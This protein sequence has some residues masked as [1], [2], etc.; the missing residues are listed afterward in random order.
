MIQA[1][2]VQQLNGHPEGA[3]D[4][5]LYWMTHSRRVLDN[6]ALEFAVEQANRLKKPLF[7]LYL[8]GM[9]EGSL[10]RRTYPFLRQGLL[11]TAGELEQ[12]KIPFL[13][14]TGPPG[15]ELQKLARRAVLV[16]T[17]RGYLQEGRRSTG[18]A[19]RR[20]S[21]PL[22]QVESE[23]V[24]PVDTAYPREAYS[25]AV[26]RPRISRLLFAYLTP[27]SQRKV[28]YPSADPQEAPGLLPESCASPL[29][30]DQ[31]LSPVPGRTGGTREA[32]SRLER[33]LEEDLDRFEEDRNN[34]GL[35]CGSGLSPYLHFGQ[36]SPLTLA[37]AAQAANSPGT[38][39]FIE[40]LIIRRELSFN[41]CFYNPDYA[42]FEGLPEWARK[43]LRLHSH[44]PRE[45]VYSRED[46]DRGASHD[47]YWNA[48]QKELV[49]SGSIHGYMRMYWGKKIIEWSRSPE[50][51]FTTAL[52]L[53]NRYSLDGFDPNSYAGVAWCFGKHD[54]P[55][56]ERSIFG[57]IRYMNDK[58]LN[59]KFPME[60]YL[61]R[62]EALGQKAPPDSPSSSGL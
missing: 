8:T 26:L 36:I 9:D 28:L 31:G 10:T 12:R 30:P 59:R 3:G 58:G 24:V 16:V 14:R 17:D 40:E 25:A 34:P 32:L 53:N 50:E 44:D 45:W 5:V 47:P 37:L 54:R 27:L 29:W 42:R 52:E 35:V 55:W 43:T 22:F 15:T 18:E 41:F 46:L 1:S 2:R 48:A 7:A 49:L 57:S 51:A 33:F 61:E 62:I 60:K 4:F 21:C 39:R 23:A 38:G 6:H 20:L 11:E 56:K 19:A 13:F